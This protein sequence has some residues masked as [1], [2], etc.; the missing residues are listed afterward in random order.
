[1]TD[2]IVPD[3]IV[4]VRDIHTLAAAIDDMAQQRVEDRARQAL[5]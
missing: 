3:R 5:L 1:M 4:P 2:H